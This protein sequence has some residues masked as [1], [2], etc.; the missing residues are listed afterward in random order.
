MVPLLSAY[1]DKKVYFLCGQSLQ[2][3]CH[4][5]SSCSGNA[6]KE[7]SIKML[8]DYMTNHEDVLFVSYYS[9]SS[10]KNTDW[11]PLNAKIKVRFIK[12][13]DAN[14]IDKSNYYI[15]EVSKI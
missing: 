12:K 15:F 10:N 1:L 14:I 6:T 4:W 8:T 2:S 3:F 9:L 7:K 11:T 13:F 5:D